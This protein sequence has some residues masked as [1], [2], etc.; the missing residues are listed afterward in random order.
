MTKRRRPWII[1]KTYSFVR[2][3]QLDGTLFEGP[4]VGSYLISN[5]RIL[6]G[7]GRVSE[8]RWPNLRK[9]I[10]TWPPFEPHELDR[11]AKYNRIKRYWRVRNLQEVMTYLDND[12]FVQ[13]VIPIH[14]GWMRPRGGLIDI[15]PTTGDMTEN[16]SIVV[17]GFDKSKGILRFWNNWGTQW[18]DKGYGYLTFEYFDKYFS[19]AWVYDFSISELTKQE[20]KIHKYNVIKRFAHKSMFGYTSAQ[21][22]IWNV[23]QNERVGWCFAVIRDEW[24]EIEDFFLRNEYKTHTDFDRIVDDIV[25]SRKFFNLPI[26]YWIPDADIHAKGANFTNVNDLIKILGLKVRKSGVPWAPYRADE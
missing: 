3:R 10:D 22:E 11:I 19:D 2:A 23:A 6:A 15:P 16:H 21:I 18:G 20:M 14:K 8:R 17:E 1:S 26:R 9:G 4:R 25:Q 12:C 24:F 7:W 5:A 13:I